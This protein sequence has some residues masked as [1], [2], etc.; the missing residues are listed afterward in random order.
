ML[1][2]K[3]IILT[4]LISFFGGM[5]AI[6]SQNSDPIDHQIHID[7]M[8]NTVDVFME[9]IHQLEKN[10]VNTKFVT[11]FDYSEPHDENALKAYNKIKS[12]VLIPQKVALTLNSKIDSLKKNLITVSQTIHHK[13]KEHF[14]KNSHQFQHVEMKSLVNQFA[15]PTLNQSLNIFSTYEMDLLNQ[16]SIQDRMMEYVVTTIFL[17][18]LQNTT[19]SIDFSGLSVEQTS[20]FIDTLKE[21]KSLESIY[22]AKTPQR[23]MS[24]Y[25]VS[26]LYQGANYVNETIVKRFLGFDV[27]K[28]VK[29][30]FTNSSPQNDALHNYK[31]VIS[32]NLLGKTPNAS[33]LE[34]FQSTIKKFSKNVVDAQSLQEMS[35]V[36]R[37]SSSL[38][39]IIIMNESPNTINLLNSHIESNNPGSKLRFSE[40][41]NLKVPAELA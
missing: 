34:L 35:R 1:K 5:D 9:K 14:D 13:F 6:S 30:K 32:N 36:L 25:V 23:E 38:K 18:F 37:E 17:P 31:T 26:S 2:K 39:N 10:N 40:A 12:K 11:G 21:F 22:L 7:N 27:I 29:S 8:F 15:M 24:D 4:L 20:H 41:H 3:L 19:K 33:E 28:V 16:F